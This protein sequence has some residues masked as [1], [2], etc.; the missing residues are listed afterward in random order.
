MD[1]APVPLAPLA[2]A[3]PLVTAARSTAGADH[4]LTTV[5]L[6]ASLPLVLAKRFVS[7]LFS[8]CIKV[9]AASSVDVLVHSKR[10]RMM[11]K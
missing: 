8:G 11:S 7:W 5:V 9:E 3:P 4:R 10:F 2:R 1:P 6:A